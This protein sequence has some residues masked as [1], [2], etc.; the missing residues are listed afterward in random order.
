MGSIFGIYWH[1]HGDRNPQCYWMSWG[2]P[3]GI[4]SWKWW[5]LGVAKISGVLLEITENIG[6]NGSSLGHLTKIY[7]GV[8]TPSFNLG[9][10]RRCSSASAARLLCLCIPW[11]I[12]S[13]HHGVV[14][15][16]LHP[17]NGQ[18][19]RMIYAA[20]FLIIN[21]IIINP[22]FG[23]FIYLCGTQDYPVMLVKQQ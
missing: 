16:S 11:M 4:S 22:I 6:M 20:I 1:N 14:P 13:N 9:S 2:I 15:R 3:M 10:H 8:P 17:K 5:V 18:N 19:T 23:Y 21:S 7:Q 12:A